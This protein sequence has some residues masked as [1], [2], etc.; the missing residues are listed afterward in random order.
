MKKRK[1]K[2][3]KVQ[4]VWLK[5][6]TWHWYTKVAIVALFAVIGFFIFKFSVNTYNVY[7]LDNAEVKMR[8]L[9]FPKAQKTEYRRSCSFRSVKFGPA[10]SPR[11]SV[12]RVDRYVMAD[13]KEAA[14]LVSETR[15]YISSAYKISGSNED[16]DKSLSLLVKDNDSL[17]L[18]Y[19]KFS[20][21]LVCY[22]VFRFNNAKT[23]NLSQ[24]LKTDEIYLRMV[25]SCYKDMQFQIYPES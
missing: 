14:H 17:T 25:T 2:S 3:I 5:I 22:T 24:E 7:L 8:Q 19:E 9:D 15:E 13:S 23:A 20:P 18:E 6:A 21:N 4:S 1:N 16:K 12:Y 10:G 11:C